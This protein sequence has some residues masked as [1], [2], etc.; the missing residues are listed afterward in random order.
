MIGDRD[1]SIQKGISSFT[2][3]DTDGLGGAVLDLFGEP[4]PCGFGGPELV[5][6]G[7]AG[8]GLTRGTTDHG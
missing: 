1:F 4:A 7:A 8:A 6:T 5:T 2:P 3:V